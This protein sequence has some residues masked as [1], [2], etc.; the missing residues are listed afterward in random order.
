MTNNKRTSILGVEISELNYQKALENIKS[1][2][3]EDK[4]KYVC[5]ANVHLVMECQKDGRLLKRVNNAGLVTP[6]GIPLVWLSKL[7]GKKGIERVY[8]PDL[9]LKVCQ[10]SE[11][12]GY[13]IFLLGGNRGRSKHLKQILIKK[14]PSL[15]VVGAEDTPQRPI[16]TKKNT[17]IIEKINR[18]G[19]DIVLV[20]MGCPHQELWMSKNCEKLSSNVLIGVGAAFDFITKSVKQS[21]GWMQTAG[22]EWLFRLTQDP[23]RLFYRYTVLNSLFIIVIVRQLFNDFILKRNL[24]E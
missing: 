2:I 20:G 16:P 13:S 23:K 12:E 6:D 17:Q 1:W 4:R 21:P 5:V 11:K 9:T 22:L 14:F 7:Y 15:S 3:D 24:A 10:L 18:S 8:G 19:A